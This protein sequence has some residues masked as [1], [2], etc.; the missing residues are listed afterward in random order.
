HDTNKTAPGESDAPPRG[1]RGRSAISN[2]CTVGLS[3]RPLETRPKR[4][5]VWRGAGGTGARMDPPRLQ[6]RSA[7]RAQRSR[8]TKRAATW[9]GAETVAYGAGNRGPGEERAVAAVVLADGMATRMGGPKQVLP[10]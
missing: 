9:R 1:D 5:K 3:G 8:C 10:V 4:G 7:P 6:G 2:R